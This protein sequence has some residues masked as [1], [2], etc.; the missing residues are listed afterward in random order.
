MTDSQPQSLAILVTCSPK[1]VGFRHTLGLARA[2]IRMGMRVFV[3]L[4][5]DAVPG[6]E[7]DETQKLKSE[8]VR[9]F[10]CSHGALTRKIPMRDQAVFSGL[11]TLS[12]LIQKADRFVCFS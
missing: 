1:S 5:H 10:A 4:L 11:P 12:D 3:Y 2:G 9:L 6:V 7:M 8:G